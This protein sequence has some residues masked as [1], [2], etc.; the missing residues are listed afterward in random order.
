[1]SGHEEF[2]T[3]RAPVKAWVKG[4]PV[5]EAA[6]RQLENIARLPFIHSHVAAMAAQRDL[7]AVEHTLKQ[8]VCVKG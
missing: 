8:V 3:G 5:E 1:M 6:R 7:V 2:Q 4:V